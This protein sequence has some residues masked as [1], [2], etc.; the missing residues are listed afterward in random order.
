M[1]M[2]QLGAAFHWQPSEI[3]LLAIEDVNDYVQQALDMGL[4]QKKA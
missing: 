2:A 4:L 3:K 1:L